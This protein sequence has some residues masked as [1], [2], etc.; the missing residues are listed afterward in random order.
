MMSEQLF[1]RGKRVLVTGASG[2]VGSNLAPLLQLKG[3]TLLAPSR[4]EYDL[5]EQH[6]VRL[7]LKD[8]R[9]DV[10]FHLAALSAGIMAN[11]QYPADFCYQNLLMNTTM[12]HES[13]KAGVR[14]YITL[15]GGCSYPA[16]A[17]SPISEDRLWNGYPQPESA[18]YSV[19]KK[20]NVTMAEAYRRQHDFD[21]IVLTPGNLYGPYDNFDLQNSHVIPALIR[22]FFTAQSSALEEVV[23]WGT[24]APVRDFIYVGDA[25]EAIVLA[26]ETYSEP[27]IINIS[28]GLQVTIRELAETLAEIVGYTGR[29]RW[30]TS[31]PDGQMY[32]G[33]DVA[34]MHERL[35]YRC[36]TSLR[37]G[38]RK[39]VDWFAAHQATARLSTPVQALL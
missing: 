2:F 23:V 36:R 16:N 29:I 28:S 37:E 34:R 39:T 4:A 20:M 14:K 38:L 27:G 19:A 5:L 17:P 9:P 25:C 15:I 7:L 18:P 35:G 30:D 6:K 13:F 31:K 24:G 32:K 3:C 33:F 12:M 21:A 22:K 1:W 10:V 26:A 11:K 8:T